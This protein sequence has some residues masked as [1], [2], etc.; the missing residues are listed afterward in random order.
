VRAGQFSPSFKLAAPGTENRCFS[1]VYGQKSLDLQADSR[2][3]RDLWVNALTVLTDP[4]AH[5]ADDPLPVT[6]H[7][8]ITPSLAPS[9][10]QVSGDVSDLHT[11]LTAPAAAGRRAN[12]IYC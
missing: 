9:A 2:Y 3:T 8:P 11:S 12:G 7:A 1:I 5:L 10:L 6:F 4:S